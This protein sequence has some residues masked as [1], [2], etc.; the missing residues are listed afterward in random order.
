MVTM[1]L[2][3]LIFWWLPWVFLALPRLCGKLLG[4]K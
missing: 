2:L 4:E 3:N 1:N